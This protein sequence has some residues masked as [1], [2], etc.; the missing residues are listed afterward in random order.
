M[1]LKVFKSAFIFLGF[2]IL[3]SGFALTNNEKEEI[4]TKAI[5][6]NKTPKK[7]IN[8]LIVDGFSNHDWK[9]TTKLTKHILEESGLFKVSVSTAPARMVDTLLV[10]WEPEFQKY[11]V[12]IQNC[13]NLNHKEIQ[14]PKKVKS[15]LENYVKSGGGLYI[16]H[17]ANNSFEEWPEYNTMIGLG[18][19]KLSYGEAIEI[20]SDKSIIKIPAGEGKNT[21]HGARF[22]A[23]VQRYT[24]HAINRGYPEKWK[25]AN[26]ELYTYARGPAKN[27]TVLSFANDSI[28][29]KNWPVEWIIKY[30]K[31]K[32]Y[33]TSMG[34]LW[35]GDVYP[36]GYRCVGFQTT[37]IRT[38]EWL[39]TRRVTYKIPKNFPTE[40]NTSLVP[41]SIIE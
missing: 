23:V 35:K 25:T 12:V 18:W 39:A 38:T 31:G 41:E 32:V 22:D 11:D 29:N 34:H 30:G 5:S 13:N 14:W 26:M 7:L 21:T 36:K 28:T 15:E 9:Q 2:I 8:V 27:V 20:A 33:N 6:N 1:Q 10:N 16:L 37:L 4:K 40:Q 3:F 24:K 17:S 19:R